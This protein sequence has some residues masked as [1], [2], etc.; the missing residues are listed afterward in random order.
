MLPLFGSVR[1]WIMTPVEV[2]KER[3]P[4]PPSTSSHL[5]Q[6]ELAEV[7]SAVQRLTREQLAIVYKWAD[8]L[9][10]PTPPGHWNFI[11]APYISKAKFTEVPPIAVT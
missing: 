5:M 4:A 1:T 11:A 6:E 7:K 10:T 2:A 3:P 9:S 8:G